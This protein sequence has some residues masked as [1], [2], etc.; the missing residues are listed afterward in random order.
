M[1]LHMRN[2][3]EI[4]TRSI[5]NLKPGEVIGITP[6][7]TEPMPSSDGDSDLASCDSLKDSILTL[8]SAETV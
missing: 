4:N 3:K 5:L 6:D 8:S 2:C 7:F 1:L